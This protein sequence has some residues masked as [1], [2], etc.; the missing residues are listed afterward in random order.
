M[1]ASFLIYASL[2]PKVSSLSLDLQ[3]KNKEQQQQK[4]S[5]C[6]RCFS[7]LLGKRWGEAL[8]W[9]QGGAGVGMD[10]INQP[11]LS[12]SKAMGWQNLG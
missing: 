11:V 1:V 7:H 10:V 9:F 6:T 8:A 5:L 4:T 12:N 2:L 3:E